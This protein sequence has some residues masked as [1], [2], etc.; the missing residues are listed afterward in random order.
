MKPF[1]H[2]L[3][4]QKFALNSL[5][6]MLHHYKEM[7]CNAHFSFCRRRFA[8]SAPDDT[9]VKECLCIPIL[10]QP[11]KELVDPHET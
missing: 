11:T 1:H 2:T 4:L 5:R 10:I 8:D 3:G 9:M 7:R 6:W